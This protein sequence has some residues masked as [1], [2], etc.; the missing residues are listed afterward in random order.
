M[1]TYVS[2]RINFTSKALA[3][4]YWKLKELGFLIPSRTLLHFFL[5]ITIVKRSRLCFT[6]TSFAASFE[7][8]M[9]APKV[10]VSI[11]NSVSRVGA[12]MTMISF[13]P[14]IFY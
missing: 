3:R 4:S 12:G 8:F 14:C 9:R 10:E 2:S 5:M 1:T 11:F 6:S 13:R 7:L